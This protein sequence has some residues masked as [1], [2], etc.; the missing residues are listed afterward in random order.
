M[1]TQ[2]VQQSPVRVL[3]VDDSALM[4]RLLSE[5]LGGEPMIEVVGA[6]PDPLVARQMIKALN[7]D[8]LTL[9]VEMPRMDGLAFLERLMTLRPMPVV[10]ISSL[11]DTGAEATLRALELGAVDY[12]AKPRVDLRHGIKALQAE[13]VSKVR[14][15]AAARVRGPARHVVP[16]SPATSGFRGSSEKLV[17][18]GAST[19]GVETLQEILCALPA[20]APAIL[21][22][23]HMPPRFTASLAARLDRLTAV[24][25]AEACHGARVLPGHVYIAPGHQHLTLA[26]SGAD[27]VCALDDGALVSGHRPSVD[28]LFRSVAKAAGANAVGVILTGMGRDGAEGMLAMR[29]AGAFTIGEDERSCVVYGMPRAAKELG[30]TAVELASSR[31]AGELLRCCERSGRAPRI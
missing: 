12:V 26:R 5:C 30:A 3:I 15:A 7:P 14:T 17:A 9:D 27:Y 23:Q 31:I 10:M 2:P 18:I 25:V 4:R 21:I 8:V 16:P 6:A 11:T 20:D 19:G 24:R 13:L 22:A 29:Q 28:V 1:S